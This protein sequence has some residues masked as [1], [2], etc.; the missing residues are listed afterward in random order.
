MRTMQSTTLMISGQVYSTAH[1]DQHPLWWPSLVG[2]TIVRW[3]SSSRGA[4]PHLT[5]VKPVRVVTPNCYIAALLES[6]QWGLSK[7]VMT[8]TTSYLT[9]DLANELSTID[10][11]FMS[12]QW[13]G[14]TPQLECTNEWGQ[15]HALKKNSYRIPPDNFRWHLKEET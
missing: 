6:S 3:G 15:G 9:V 5:A 7:R 13:W 2:A 12:S 8:I 11:H 1:E 14:S 10:N 4:D